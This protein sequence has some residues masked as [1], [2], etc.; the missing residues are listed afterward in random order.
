LAKLAADIRKRVNA[1]LR[2]ETEQGPLRRLQADFKK[3]L[4]HDLTDDD[5]ADMYA[6]TI[7]YGLLTARVSRPAGLVAENVADMVPITNPFLRDLL[8]TFLTVGGRKGKIDFDEVG[9]NEVVQTLRDKNTNMEAVLRDFGDR[10]PEEDPVIF[11]YED[12]LKA[13]DARKKVKRGVFYTPRPVVSYIVRSIHELLQREFGLKDGLADTTTWGEMASKQ[14]GLKIPDGIAA[15][16]PFVQILD[17]ATGTGTFLVEVIDVIHSALTI[18]WQGQGLSKAQ[19][20]VAWNDYV[21][22]HLLPRVHGYELM[23]AP[24][25]IAH[26]KIGLKLFGTGYRFGSDERARVYLTNTLEPASDEQLRL[27]GFLPSLAQEAQAVNEIKRKQRFTVIIGNPPYSNYG[28]LNKIPFILDLL[29]DY[30]RG[31]VEKK[32]NLDDDF[33]KFVRYGQHQLDKSGVG[34]FGMITNSTYLDGITHR[35]MRV[36]LL[37]TFSH[38][39]LLDIHGSSKRQEKNPSGGEDENVFDIQ[40]GVAIALFRKKATEPVIEHADLWGT[41]SEKYAK[42]A[43]TSVSTTPWVRLAP[44]PPYWFF[45]PKE[46]SLYN[47]YISWMALKDVFVVGGCGIKTERDRVSIHWTLKECCQAVEDFRTLPEHVLREKYNLPTDSR[48]WKI[49]NAVADVKRQGYKS[50]FRQ[51]LYRPF[52]VRH[53]WYSGQTRGFVGTPGFPT[54][55]HMR[56]GANFALLTCRQQ[57]ELGF[58]HVFCSR[59]IAECCTV[60]LKTREITSVFPLFVNVKEEG[61]KFYGGRAANFTSPFLRSLCSLLALPAQKPHGLPQG[62]RPEEIFCYAYALFH[63]PNFRDRYAEFLKI[64]FPRL[65]LT[66]SLNLFRLLSQVGGVIVALHLMESPILDQHV[67]TYIGPTNP[68]IEK[69]SLAGHTVWLD[70]AQTCG[71][72]GVPEKVWNFHVGGYQV[73]HKWLKDRQGRTLSGED[74]EHYQRIVVALSETI[75]LMKEIDE[76]IDKYGGWPGAFS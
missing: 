68:E 49:F 27:A 46:M 57:A 32:L 13:Y 15:S 41:R 71:F 7:T 14:L 21:P 2:M 54:M 39:H 51:V 73:C 12:F 76:V 36:S 26:M 53:I 52:D 33:I 63:S 40:T 17:P 34:M 42:L 3:A 59:L 16:T 37:E 28:Q 50:L 29:E 43:G 48:D 74:I 31:L 20:Q 70:K 60:S 64:D 67:T 44:Q 56:D 65:P 45:R 8:S 1:I 19:Q 72:R 61:L 5:F 11:F 38:L 66:R 22:K 9:I 55:R 47:E 23:M 58:H 75:R 30:K 25:A 35:Q 62:I 10:K 18:K 6:Q 69:V 24:Y 4:I